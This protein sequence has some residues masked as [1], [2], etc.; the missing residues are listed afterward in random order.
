M[1]KEKKAFKEFK[2]W[3]LSEFGHTYE[4]DKNEYYVS[5]RAEGAIKAWKYLLQVK[6]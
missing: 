6:E 3:Y 1:S 2:E 4:D 5:L